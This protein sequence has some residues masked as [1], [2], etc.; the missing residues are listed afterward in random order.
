M[1]RFND[2]FGSYTTG[3]GQPAGYTARWETVTVAYDIIDDVS[4]PGGKYLEI[5][6]SGSGRPLITLDAADGDDQG[7]VALL[8]FQ[9]GSGVGL[10]INAA[11]TEAAPTGYLVQ[12]TESTNT[13]GLWEGTGGG[14]FTNHDNDTSLTL[15]A[16][17]K[18]WV[19]LMRFDDGKVKARVWLETD[20]EPSTW[21]VE[22]TDSSHITGWCGVSELQVTPGQT[23]K[24]HYLST[25][26]DYDTPCIVEDADFPLE[27]LYT[28]LSSD[29]SIRVT[30]VAGDQT[31]V[32]K[33]FE[34]GEILQEVTYHTGKNKIYATLDTSAAINRYTQYGLAEESIITGIVDAF[35]VTFDYA[36]DRMYYTNRQ[37]SS[38][39][40]RATDDGGSPTQIAS[41]IVWGGHCYFNEDDGFVYATYDDGVRS[42]DS[43]GTVQVTYS[44]LNQLHWVLVDGTNVMAGAWGIAG[45][46]YIPIAGGSW[47][48]ADSNRRLWNAR[49]GANRNEIYA[50]AY[51]EDELI[52]YDTLPPPSSGNKTTVDSGEHHNQIHS[53]SYVNLTPITLVINTATPSE[54]KVGDEIVLSGAGFTG[55]TAVNFNGTPALTFTVDSDTQITV[56]VPDSATSG[57][58][59]VV[60]PS[61]TQSS[62]FTFNILPA[63]PADGWNIELFQIQVN[64]GETDIEQ[65]SGTYKQYYTEGLI[66]DLDFVPISVSNLEEFVEADEGVFR[67]GSLDITTTLLD[68]TYFN[69]YKDYVTSP[70]IVLIRD[71]NDNIV[72][73]GPV[74]PE[75]CNYDAKSKHTTFRALSWDVLLEG[76]SAPCRSIFETT[77]SREYSDAIAAGTNST[78]YVKETINGTD[79]KTVVVAGSV[80]VF[81][82]PAGE[83]RAIV[84]GHQVDGDD[85]AVLIN[86]QPTVYLAQNK[87]ILAAE[88]EVYTVGSGGLAFRR[89]EMTFD[90]TG[91]WENLN[92]ADDDVDGR[93]LLI[94]IDVNGKNYT[95]PLQ[96]A[97]DTSGAWYDLDEDRSEIKIYLNICSGVCSPATIETDF[98]TLGSS[99]SITST[100]KINAGDAVRILGAEMY[101]YNNTGAAFAPILHFQI[102]GGVLQGMFSL[103]DLGVLPYIV[104][105]FVFPAGFDKK[106]DRW[107]ELPPNL[108]DA[109]H[110]IQNTHGLLLRLTATIGPGGLPR[111]TVT[112]RDR[113]DANETDAPVVTN[114][115]D[116]IEW[117][118]SAAD[119]TPTAVVVNAHINYFEPVGRVED[120]GFYFDGLDAL[121]PQT[122]GK[123]QNGRVVEIT[124]NTTPSYTGDVFFGDGVPV[125]NDDRLKAI[126]KKF[127]EYYKNLSRP[128]QFKIEGT[129]QED[130]LTKIIQISETDDPL[131]GTTFTRTVFVEGVI[132]DMNTNQTVI[133]GRIGGFTGLAG[134]NPVPIITGQ[135]VYT[136]ADD[137][138]D[139]VVVLS[140]LSSYDPQ[141]DDIT[142][143][144]KEGA[145]SLSTSPI[146][147]AT[148]STGEHTIT[149]EVTDSDSNVASTTAVVQV[150]VLSETPPDGSNIQA[151][152]S[153]QTY[154][155]N[156][157]GDLSI[158]V[159]GDARTQTTN[160]IKYRTATTQVGLDSASDTPA[161]NPQIGLEIASGLETNETIWVRITLVN[162]VD[163]TDSTNDWE[164]SVT[165]TGATTALIIPSNTAPTSSSDTS[166]VDGEIRQDGSFIYVKDATNGWIRAAL[167]TF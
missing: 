6:K 165:N 94:S 14:A 143:E 16:G 84:L 28:T 9:A 139:E 35:G 18:Y 164:F 101:G 141:G 140:A 114:I 54:G 136:D 93:E 159:T 132:T 17:T 83:Y 154:S 41:G 144:W 24:V 117:S 87:S 53:V 5:V 46:W 133:R 120:V 98:L 34:E 13:I 7:I 74:D 97:L 81:D 123:P 50:C 148:L 103:A 108:L 1:A 104:D 163:G 146:M 155:I 49:F 10:W 162:D 157:D 92:S 4:S 142:Y 149:L 78:V 25:A 21:N 63:I 37:A 27:R 8:E 44:G 33:I 15:T 69:N 90:D 125:R 32:I 115:T 79:M 62:T 135:L 89:L 167:S 105:T 88:H 119:L 20:E 52:K 71:P 160:G 39:L 73:H 158:S 77:F 147:E 75:T 110:Q 122:T 109:L 145:T 113:E 131:A 152:F 55:A 67:L 166:G 64:A 30:N 85:L 59:E 121:D 129:P 57:L 11:G 31:F 40:F 19:R 124:V 130:L 38:E 82:T 137:S 138:G 116:I 128:C 95:M 126:A 29:K 3:G 91:I 86:T 106:V 76:T 58:I 22:V 56:T 12:L 61:A 42:Y 51:Y 100:T 2:N 99:I 36:N 70:F 47:T 48:N 161:N 102:N 23:A 65:V 60:T 153:I 72:F 151:D 96:D 156:S 80:L 66:N 107:A 150:K 45:L 127:Y 68:P 112:V 118:E 134:E 43:D 111:V 26:T